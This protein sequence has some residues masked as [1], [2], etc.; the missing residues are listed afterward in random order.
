MTDLF[1]VAQ[2]YAAGYRKRAEELKAERAARVA[3]PGETQLEYERALE[4]LDSRAETASKMVEW[5]LTKGEAFLR[6]VEE[7]KRV[8]ASSA[9]R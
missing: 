8:S 7:R 2:E 5:W 3:E 1:L 6:D 4:S 9:S